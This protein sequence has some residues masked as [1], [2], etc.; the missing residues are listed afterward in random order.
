MPVLIQFT[1]DELT[2]ELYDQLIKEVD[3]VQV[4]ADDVGLI[5]HVAFNTDNGFTVVDVWNSEEEFKKFAHERLQSVFSKHGLED[6]AQVAPVYNVV[7]AE[8]GT[9]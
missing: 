2:E 8:Y 7:A 3:P 5:T 1:G 9:V 4:R 6:T